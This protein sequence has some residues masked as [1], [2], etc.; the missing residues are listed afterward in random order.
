MKQYTVGEISKKAGVSAH[1]LRHYDKMGLMKPSAVSENGYRLYTEADLE[2][3]QKIVSLRRLDLPL[4]EIQKLIQIEQLDEIYAALDLQ[5]KKFLDEIERMQQIIRVIERLEHQESFQWEQLMDLNRM[6]RIQSEY[7]DYEMHAKRANL[8]KYSTN[9]ER[10]HTFLFRQM[11]IR[12]GQR[13]LEIDARDGQLWVDNA[14]ELPP[15]TITQSVYRRADVIPLQKAL[16][17]NKW[18]HPI[19]FHYAVV[20]LNTFWLPEGSYDIIVANHLYTRIEELDAVLNVCARALKPGGRLFCAAIG[21]GHMKELFDLVK[22]YDGGIRF[23]RMETLNKFSQ[24][25]GAERLSPYFRRVQW[26]AHPDD[27]VIDHPQPIADYVWNNYSNAQVLLKKKRDDLYA[28][29]SRQIEAKGPILIH[30]EHG[31]FCASSPIR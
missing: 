17:K 13:I 10:W 15:C 5:K 30:K 16:E 27:I 28:Y 19:R 12:P 8:H 18:S 24:N 1:I 11:K 20:P 31:V 6:I 29:I 3:I 2:T 7:T 4:A 23:D 26:Q 21:E 9:A 22:A 25:T 14:A